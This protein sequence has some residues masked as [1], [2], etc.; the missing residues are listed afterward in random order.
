MLPNFVPTPHAMAPSSSA[1]SE[2][3]IDANNFCPELQA[4][5]LNLLCPAWGKA[6]PNFFPPPPLSSTLLFSSWG[7]YRH[8]TRKIIRHVYF[9]W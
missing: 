3:C 7:V 9:T 2:S 8:T 5:C 4:V 1:V 6:F